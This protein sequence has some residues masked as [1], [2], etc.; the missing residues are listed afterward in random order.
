MVVCV[1]SSV[2]YSFSLFTI[3]HHFVVLVL[4]PAGSRHIPIAVCT[5]YSRPSHSSVPSH[6]FCL[7]SSYALLFRLYIF[8]DFFFPFSSFLAQ[9]QVPG[10]Y[11]LSTHES[12][13]ASSCIS[14]LSLLVQ[15][16]SPRSNGIVCPTPAVFHVGKG[17]YMMG[18][19]LPR[20]YLCP[21]FFFFDLPSEA[22][23][24]PCLCSPITAKA[25]FYLYSGSLCMRLRR[26]VISRLESPT[27]FSWRL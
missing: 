7:T 14:R 16:D 4:V 3:V 19:A 10:T 26:L 8:S 23:Q 20:L 22:L 12:S 25:F 5:Y 17:L 24:V 18:C 11:E 2:G 21:L 6:T 1:L 27:E 15:Y 9:A 13:P